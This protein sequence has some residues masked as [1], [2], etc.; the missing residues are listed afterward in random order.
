MTF[1]HPLDTTPR[2]WVWTASV[3]MMVCSWLSYV[4]RQILAVL[5]PV[6]L[7]DTGMSAQSYATV[8]SAFSLAYMIANPV[9][10]SLLDYFGLRIG[11][12][13]AVGLWT[14]ASASHSLMSGFWGFAAARALL[15][16]GEGATFPGGFRTAM[17]SLPKE[18]QARGIA[19][20]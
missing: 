5:S 9:W 6:I 4:D 3:V 7:M 17:D 15:G 11:M 14:V 20:S 2:Y 8:V 16:F 13:A 19:S 18:K 10:G 12:L 1:R